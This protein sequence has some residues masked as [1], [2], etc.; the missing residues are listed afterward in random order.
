[1]ELALAFPFSLG[2]VAAFNPC[3]FA[4]LPTYLSY[5]L[6]L[7]GG[8][9]S[10]DDPSA[11]LRNVI[12]AIVVG[13]V[14]TLGFM[15]VFGTVGLLVETVVNQGTIFERVPYF[16][17]AFGVLI[18]PLG[19]AMIWGF[20]PVLRLPKMSKGT[21]S[22]E[23]PSVFMFGVSYAVVSLSCTAPLFIQN[24]VGSFSNSNTIDGAERSYI[25]RVVEGTGTFLAYGAGMGAVI[26]FLTL[27]LAMARSN[28]ARNMRRVLPWVNRVSGVLLVLAGIYLIIYGVWEIQVLNGDITENRLVTQFETMQANVTNWITDTTPQ[29]LGVVALFGITGALLAGW[30]AIERDPVKRLSVTISWALAYLIVEFGFNGGEFIFLPLIRLIGGWP[31][32]VGHWFTDS[33]RWGVPIEIVVTTLGIWIVVR[34]LRRVTDRPARVLTPTSA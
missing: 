21:G 30:R 23:L 25:E 9:D 19:I 34:L 18:V 32:R 11:L 4:M 24:V 16:T 33:A 7:E 20:N 8:D 12:R 22:R 6:G 13:V 15:V 14:L 17:V 2:M 27:S 31:A 29:R 5:F 1:M 10:A 3:G 26:L 28:V